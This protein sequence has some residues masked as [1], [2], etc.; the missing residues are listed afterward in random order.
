[1]KWWT[2]AV[3]R[4]EMLGALRPATRNTQK[5]SGLTHLP[6]DLMNVADLLD[7]LEH[8]GQLRH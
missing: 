4:H 5:R 3:Q 7:A 8:L 6:G 1:M 2:Y